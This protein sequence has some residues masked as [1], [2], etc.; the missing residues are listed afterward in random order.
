MSHSP[1]SHQC[2]HSIVLYIQDKL[3]MFLHIF[4]CKKHMYADS[5]YV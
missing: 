3:M 2:I 1:D 4:L 5:I